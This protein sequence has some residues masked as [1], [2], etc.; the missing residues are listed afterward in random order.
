MHKWGREIQIVNKM[1]KLGF[2]DVKKTF[3]S[4]KNRKSSRKIKGYINRRQS[5]DTNLMIMLLIGQ[6]PEILKNFVLVI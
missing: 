6:L 5:C 2:R 3:L 1:V 4:I